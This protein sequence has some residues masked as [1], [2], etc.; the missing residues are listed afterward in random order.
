[1][2]APPPRDTRLDILR[3]WLQLT[4]FVSHASTAWIYGW[5][6]YGAWGLS[7]SSEQFVFLSGY[8]LGSVFA[9]R[10]A[11]QGR[12][13][14]A[15]DMLRRA[16]RLYRRHLVVFV[17][18]GALIIAADRSGWLPG[19][20][21]RLGWTVVVR[22]PVHAIPGALAMLSLPKFMDILPLFIGCMLL[23]P[24]FAAVE[25]AVGGFA[26]LAP[27]AL[28]AAVWRFGLKPPDID[29]TGGAGFNPFAWQL[30][31]LLGACLGRRALLTARPLPASRWATALALS[32]VLAGVAVRLDWSGVLA[33]PA[34]PPASPMFDKQNLAPPLIAHASP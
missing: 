28:Y 19:E 26:M 32:I 18:F 23:L 8:V 2:P 7:D 27:L 15:L 4:I 12:P 22:D 29:G 20:I 1:M 25:S 13:A 34:P 17:L 6:V 9:R 31:F 24:A 21:D 14:A 33:W 5:L 30:L 3:G 16:A 10:T 11:M